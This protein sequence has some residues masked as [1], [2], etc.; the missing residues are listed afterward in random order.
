M[1]HRTEQG[2]ARGL[3]S[4]QTEVGGSRRF[5][6]KKW[7]LSLKYVQTLIREEEKKSG[8][9]GDSVAG[10]KVRGLKRVCW[11]EEGGEWF[12]DTWR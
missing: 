9:M 8:D 7:C 1:Q 10:S 6:H 3:N 11:L 5:S 12:C 4:K 2:R